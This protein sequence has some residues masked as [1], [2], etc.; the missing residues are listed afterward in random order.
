[1]FHQSSPKDY[2]EVPATSPPSRQSKPP[3]CS[4]TQAPE[5]FSEVS[6]EQNEHDRTQDGAH[7]AADENDSEHDESHLG[8]DHAHRPTV[9]QTDAQG[10]GEDDEEQDDDEGRHG[11]GGHDVHPGAGRLWKPADWRRDGEVTRWR[12]GRSASTSAV[13]EE[14]HGLQSQAVGCGTCRF[15]LRLCGEWWYL[16]HW[17]ATCTCFAIQRLNNYQ[18]RVHL[19]VDLRYGDI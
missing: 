12:W 3:P 14:V 5:A 17:R 2:D 18:P 4:V 19:C 8:R 13:V 15:S 9:G 10:V 7:S 11:E 6:T 16:I 1:M